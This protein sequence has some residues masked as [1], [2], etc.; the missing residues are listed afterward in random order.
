MGAMPIA[1]MT[2][3]VLHGLD[4]RDASGTSLS[5]FTTDQ[6]AQ[7]ASKILESAIKGPLS[8]ELRACINKIVYF[9]KAPFEDEDSISLRRDRILIQ[10]ASAIQMTRRSEFIDLAQDLMAGFLFIIVPPVEWKSDERII[11]KFSYE[12]PLAIIGQMFP[13]VFR[14]SVQPDWAERFHFEVKAPQG[15]LVKNIEILTTDALD[16][17]TKERVVARS[18]PGS[19]KVAHVALDGN[20]EKTPFQA[21]VDIAAERAGLPFQA[22]LASIGLVLALA[23]PLIAHWKWPWLVLIPKDGS[24]ATLL[25]LGPAVLVS[26]LARGS[27]HPVT[28][29]RLRGGRTVLALVGLILLGAAAIVGGEIY[30]GGPFRAWITLTAASVGILVFSLFWRSKST[31]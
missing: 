19:N 30:P 15:L 31:V 23:I 21:L 16:D 22:L 18:V 28:A 27:E 5:V 25:L 13:A 20:V 3:S 4:V 6:N 9:A 26:F 1:L 2:K 7:F 12:E 10:Y 14:T 24:A 29:H 11:V 8:S 17:P